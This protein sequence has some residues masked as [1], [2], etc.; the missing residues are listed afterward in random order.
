[1]LFTCWM[2]G[3]EYDAEFNAGEETCMDCAGAELEQAMHYGGSEVERA[4]YTEVY[5]DTEE[6][7]W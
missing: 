1:M 5:F 4:Q 7:V 6:D 2:C 3:E